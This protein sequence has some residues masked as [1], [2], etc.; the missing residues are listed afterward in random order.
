MLTYQ[1]G[2]SDTSLG[3]LDEHWTLMKQ[4]SPDVPTSEVWLSDILPRGASVGVDPKLVSVSYAEQLSKSLQPAGISLV[5]VEDN[6]IDLVW[7]GSQPARPRHPLRLL[8]ESVTGVSVQGKLAQ[9][10]DKLITGGAS[11]GFLATALDDVAWLLNLRGSDIEFNPVFFA[12]AY[13]GLDRAVLYTDNAEQAELE[14]HLDGAVQVRPY[15]RVWDDMR[16]LADELNKQAE[17]G[18]TRVMLP[19]TCNWALARMFEKEAREVGPSPV[20]LAKAVKSETEL[21]CMREMHVRDAAALCTF[22]A[23]V[24]DQLSEGA[25]LDEIICGDKVDALRA[26][27]AVCLMNVVYVGHCEGLFGTFLVNLRPF[28]SISVFFLSFS[29]LFPF[30]RLLQDF[31]GPSFDTI[32]ASGPNGAIVH[33]RASPATNRPVTRSHLFLCDSGGQYIGGTTDVTRT[34][35]F[36]EPTAY[37]RRCFTRVLQGHI[38]LDSTVFP[39]GTTGYQLDAVTRRPLWR[40]GKDYRHGTGHG[41]GAFLNVHE[42]PHGIGTRIVLNETALQAGMTVTNEP[43]YYELGAFGI[44]IENVVIVKHAVFSEQQKEE[45][46]GFLCFEPL[47]VVPIQTKLVDQSLLTA[48]E[49]EWINA[50]HARCR[51]VVAPRVKGRALEWLLKETEPIGV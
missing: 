8:P 45:Q 11:G 30:S 50:Y 46:S 4:G 47:T 40:E 42:G 38:A 18:K 35:H 13:V 43:G 14:A 6:L 3:E 2:I 31:V 25:E 33:Y 22:F 20:T 19:K 32:S 21:A 28:V 27:Q 7:S 36:G 15:A 17:K 16:A 12:Y 49:V 34:L 37:E 26:E 5:A 9:L 23:W 10:R 51:E 1:L 24:E 29:L 48:G 44:R 41:V 39:A